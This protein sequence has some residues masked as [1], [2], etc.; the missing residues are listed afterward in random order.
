MY[1]PTTSNLCIRLGLLFT[2][3]ENRDN[4][5]LI[6]KVYARDMFYLCNNVKVS[7][8]FL[9]VNGC[10]SFSD[11]TF[12]GTVTFLAIEI[13]L[14]CDSVQ[15]VAANFKA[16][17]DPATVIRYLDILYFYQIHKGKQSFLHRVIYE[18]WHTAL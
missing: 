5:S 3:F 15:A 4:S 14:L 1:C 12:Y 13:H 10:I 18:K 8:L 9:L 17:F 11:K 6:V 7:G 16:A 2:E